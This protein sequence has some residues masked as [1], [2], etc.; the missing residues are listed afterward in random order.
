MIKYLTLPMMGA[1]FVITMFYLQPV[2][3]QTNWVI[4]ENPVNGARQSFPNR[5][6]SGWIFI[7]H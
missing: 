2:Q 1:L 4:C 5:C 7:S 6:P 3:A